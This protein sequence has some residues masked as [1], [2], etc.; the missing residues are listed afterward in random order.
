LLKDANGATVTVVSMG[1]PQADEILKEAIA[2]GA[3]DAFLVSDRALAGSDTLA[4][5]F[6]L[7]AAVKKLVL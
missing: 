2:M 3:D 7:A 1:P 5:S 4:T 6:A